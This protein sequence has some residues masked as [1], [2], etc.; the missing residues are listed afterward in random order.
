[1]V[2]YKPRADEFI[3]DYQS[4]NNLQQMN[5]QGDADYSD[6]NLNLKSEPPSE[7]TFDHFPSRPVTLPYEAP[8]QTDYEVPQESQDEAAADDEYMQ[9]ED[10][11]VL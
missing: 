3:D 5:S 7:N 11:E 6:K 10:G 8:P 1:M 4:Q 9:N 2:N